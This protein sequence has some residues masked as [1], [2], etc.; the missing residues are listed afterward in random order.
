MLADHVG[1][2]EKRKP[3]KGRGS[4]SDPTLGSGFLDSESA[5]FPGNI[6]GKNHAQLIYLTYGAL[7]HL[8]FQSILEHSSED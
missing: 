1:G 8:L 4:N 5:V 6:L 7:I 2:N 3:R